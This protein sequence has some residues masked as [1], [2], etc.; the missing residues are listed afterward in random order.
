MDK[1]VRTQRSKTNA[2]L[3]PTQTDFGFLSLISDPDGRKTAIYKK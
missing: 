1:T 2:N 3:A